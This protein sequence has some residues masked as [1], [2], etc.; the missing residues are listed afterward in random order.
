MVFKKFELKYLL[1]LLSSVVLTGSLTAQSTPDR[2]ILGIAKEDGRA[3]IYHAQQMPLSHGYNIYKS[4]DGE[5]WNQ[6][7]D[8]VIYPASD[9]YD[10]EY[11]L[12]EQFEI[13]QQLTD[14][15]DPQAVF[16]SLRRNSGV[17]LIANFAS[18]D[19]AQEMGRLYIDENAPIGESVNYRFEIVD[20]L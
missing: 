15:T 1:L 12:Q 14:R 17:G 20:D 7:N 4:E 3:F 5:N 18:P 9:G 16:L 6:L 19:I 10:L 8:E 11:R 2:Q 13:A